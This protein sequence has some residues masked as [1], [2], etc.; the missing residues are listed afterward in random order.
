MQAKFDD[1]RVTFTPEMEASVQVFM[2]SFCK[3]MRRTDYPGADSWSWGRCYVNDLS[4]TQP[5]EFQFGS[6][7]DRPDDGWGPFAV[8]INE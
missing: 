1:R 7:E 4:T 2:E 5:F 6:E 8:M 3:M